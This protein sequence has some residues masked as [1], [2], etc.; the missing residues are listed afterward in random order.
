MS[1][2]IEF[3]IKGKYDDQTRCEDG[4]F[5]GEDCVAVI[6]GVTSQTGYKFK[7]KYGGCFAKDI[8]LSCLNTM[9]LSKFNAPGFFEF[10]NNTIGK[11]TRKLYPDLDLS[12]YPKAVMIVFNK[13]TKEIWS[14][15]DCQCMVD[16]HV[17]TKSKKID[18]F[19]SELRAAVLEE[20]IRKGK[21][22]EELLKNDSGH[23]VIKNSLKYQY[24]LANK[25]SEYGYPVL[26]GY[27]FE[28]DFIKI[29]PVKE[30]QEIVLASDGYPKLMRTLEDSE[31]YLQY[32][33]KSDPLCFREYKSTKG[34]GQ[35]RNSFD[36]RA[37][38]RGM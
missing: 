15:G 33:L 16:G 38:W 4:I 8:I 22:I 32:I 30:G 25:K 35:G 5:I 26:N 29:Y 24:L 31:T 21:S 23:S 14:Y 18:V 20:E 1:G 17:L 6:D 10:I 3:Y 12:Q 34:L 13:L 19:H 7:E 27:N 2:T 11:E 28:E 9:D 36:D 37:Y